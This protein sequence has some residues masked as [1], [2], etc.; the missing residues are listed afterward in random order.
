MSFTVELLERVS[1][2]LDTITIDW[3]Q[4]RES[5]EMVESRVYKGVLFYLFQ[6][7]YDRDVKLFCYKESGVFKTVSDL[8]I[9]KELLEDIFNSSKIDNFLSNLRDEIL[10]SAF[11][12][13]SDFIIFNPF[14]GENRVF[15]DFYCVKDEEVYPYSYSI[16][17]SSLNLLDKKPFQKKFSISYNG[18]FKWLTNSNL[19]FKPLSLDEFT[20]LLNFIGFFNSDKNNLL[21]FNCHLSYFLDWLYDDM[22]E[23][24]VDKLTL[25]L[26]KYTLLS[27]TTAIIDNEVKESLDYYDEDSYSKEDIFESNFR[28]HTTISTLKS[29]EK[30]L[31][32]I[33][34]DKR[35]KVSKKRNRSFS[36]GA[37]SRENLFNKIFFIEESRVKSAKE[38]ISRA[39]IDYR[40]PIANL[41]QK[42]KLIDEVGR[43][44]DLADRE[45][46]EMFKY[47][48]LENHNF[49][50]FYNYDFQELE[51]RTLFHFKLVSD[52]DEYLFKFL[53]K[54]LDLYLLLDFIGFDTLREYDIF[55]SEPIKD[56]MPKLKKCLDEYEYFHD[57]CIYDEILN[58][59]ENQEQ[60]IEES[61]LRNPKKDFKIEKAVS[62]NCDITHEDVY[63]SSNAMMFLSGDEL[64]NYLEKIGY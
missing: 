2:E 46:R 50:D 28:V 23:F 18:T 12:E 41:K 24:T 25:I 59:F 7:R 47:E 15:F 49:N 22:Y 14:I 54:N 40:E 8:K 20:T 51:T 55:L 6:N 36:N 27:S 16:D 32:I 34:S 30:I 1:Q 21:Q 10:N 61:K 33:T 45:A 42:V 52:S 13:K 19:P 43:T 5:Y 48:E 38:A 62:Y 31:D 39:F 3:N 35:F 64:S 37:N 44:L 4:D 56:F 17:K 26:K 60:L 63:S 11:G 58:S 29:D 57:T 53:E 9:H